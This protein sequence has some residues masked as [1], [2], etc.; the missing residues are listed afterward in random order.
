MFTGTQQETG[1]GV[2]LTGS[3]PFGEGFGDGSAIT[4]EQDR[5]NAPG[6]EGSNEVCGLG[7]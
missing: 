6:F 1:A 7:S 3:N 5:S 2:G 4:G